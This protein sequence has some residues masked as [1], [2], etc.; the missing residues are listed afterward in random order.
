[1]AKWKEFHSKEWEY[2]FGKTAP[3]KCDKCGQLSTVPM[4]IQISKYIRGD[5]QD[6]TFCSPEC[7]D[8]FY[9]D[10]MRKSGL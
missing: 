6:F 1:M 3:S 8:S 5:S 2:Q 10:R 4:P 7:H 9:L